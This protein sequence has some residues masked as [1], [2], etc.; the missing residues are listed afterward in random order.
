MNRG[1][2]NAD[3]F[4][5]L[6][7]D[8][9]IKGGVIMRIAQQLTLA[10]VILSLAACSKQP[11]EN[12]FPM[13]DGS[14]WEYSIE[15]S[16]HVAG[17]DKRKVVIRI[18]GNEEISG[19]KYHKQVTVFSGIPG[20]EASISYYRIAKDGI[21]EI[22]GKRKDQPEFLYVRFPLEV[23]R[24]WTVQ[25]PEASIRYRVEG[26]ETVELFERKYDDCMKISF[27]VYAKSG[28]YEGV[29][30][31]ASDVGCVRNVVKNRG[32]TTEVVLDKYE[33]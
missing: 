30:Y 8:L 29:S 2:L 21:Y 10:V 16:R 6:V 13:S 1:Y 15:D 31:Y 27:H 22:S 19:K 20:A 4:C 25:E 23:G 33:K 18:D 11:G 17:A 14:R 3:V 28:D 7:P 32:L 5:H 26:K 24:S 12:Y 9:R